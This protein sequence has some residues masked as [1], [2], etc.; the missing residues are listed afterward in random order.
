MWKLIYGPYIPDIQTFR[1]CADVTQQTS[2]KL[3]RAMGLNKVTSFHLGRYK[4]SSNTPVEKIIGDIHVEST[5][6]RLISPSD[7]KFT[8]TKVGRP[9]DQLE[10]VDS[11]LIPSGIVL[12]DAMVYSATTTNLDTLMKRWHFFGSVDGPGGKGLTA[13]SYGGLPTLTEA[14][15]WWCTISALD[16]DK[17]ED[18]VKVNCQSAIQCFQRSKSELPL[19]LVCY[20]TDVEAK[21]AADAVLSRF[22]FQFCNSLP[23]YFPDWVHVIIYEGYTDTVLMGILG[24]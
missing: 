13:L 18:L 10:V 9:T 23:S 22:G 19:S 11:V 8:F 3:L 12:A 17:V 14:T 4:Y 16:T 21:K 15:S 5:V 7:C 1:A 24:I 2:G 6:Q 20:F